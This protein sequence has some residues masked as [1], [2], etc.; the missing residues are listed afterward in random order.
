MQ[1]IYNMYNKMECKIENKM[2]VSKNTFTMKQYS[3]QR[4]IVTKIETKLPKIVHGIHNILHKIHNILHN[5]RT[6]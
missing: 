3:M 4:Y 1:N 6:E 5:Q 2:E